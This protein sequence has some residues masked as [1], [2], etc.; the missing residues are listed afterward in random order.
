[1]VL[2]PQLQK[3]IKKISILKITYEKTL[4][5]KYALLKIRETKVNHLEIPIAQYD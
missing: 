3:K 2:K 4:F 1:M 5:N